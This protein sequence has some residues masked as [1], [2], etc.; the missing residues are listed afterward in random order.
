MGQVLLRHNLDIHRMDQIPG[1]HTP[2]K[3]YNNYR[4]LHLIRCTVSH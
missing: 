3:A 1:H 2:R 4:I